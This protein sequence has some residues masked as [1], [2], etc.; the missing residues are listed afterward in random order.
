MI[1]RKSAGAETYAIAILLGSAMIFY[2]LALPVSPAVPGIGGFCLPDASQWGIPSLW[3]TVANWAALAAMSVAAILLNRSYDFIRGT[4]LLFPSVFFMLAASNPCVGSTLGGSTVVAA[5]AVSS[6]ALSMGEY[7]SPNSTQDIF[8]AATIISLGTMAEYACL[9]L[10]IWCPVAW[11]IMKSLR[12]KE[13][14]AFLLGIV[15]PWWCAIGTGLLPVGDIR[16]PSV[17]NFFTPLARAGQS[18]IMIAAVAWWS[19]L[20]VMIGLNAAVRLYAGNSRVRATNNAINALG[21]IFLIFMII[22]FTH[23]S[24]YVITLSFVVAVQ[25]GQLFALWPMQ[26]QRIWVLVLLALMLTQYMVMALT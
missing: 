4:S 24:S 6:L 20:A 5:V 18:G 25:L 23:V 2:T 14:M 22:D 10:V 8:A 26:R 1:A 17:E 21:F 7:K 15:A 19:F 11:A 13:L 3:S 9:P 12:V 16:I